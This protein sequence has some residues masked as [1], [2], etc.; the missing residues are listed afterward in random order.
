VH[1]QGV[2]GF[3]AHVVLIDEANFTDKALFLQAVFPT[4]V[5]RKAVCIMI[6]TPDNPDSFFMQL[7]HSKDEKGRPRMPLMTVGGP[8]SECVRLRR[9]KR[10]LHTWY[11]QP[12]WKDP[13]LYERIRF[14]WKFDQETDA[15][16]NLARVMDVSRGRFGAKL[17]ESLFAAPLF[18]LTGRPN[19]VYL[20]ADPSAGGESDFGL[21]AGYF[22]GETFVVRVSIIIYYYRCV[23]LVCDV[24]VCV[25]LFHIHHVRY[26]GIGYNAFH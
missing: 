20:A 24:C 5:Q 2:R 10:C 17:V 21:A 25:L 6:T 8:C 4:L 9:E 3:K 1:L 7:V 11:E 14:A 16:E 23:V 26:S 13:E 12:P 18:S 19:G 15:R 22:I